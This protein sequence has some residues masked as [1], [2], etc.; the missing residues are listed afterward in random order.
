MSSEK[1]ESS[2]LKSGLSYRP[3][4]WKFIETGIL[5]TRPGF[6][7]RLK[8]GTMP[9]FDKKGR[10]EW[11]CQC[12]ARIYNDKTPS[13]WIPIPGLNKSGNVCPKCVKQLE[14]D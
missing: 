2:C 6:R 4:H 13:V 5:D 7:S 8:G 3:L 9:H 14:K 1:K 11:I 12:C 10:E